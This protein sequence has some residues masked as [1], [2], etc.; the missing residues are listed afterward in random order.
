MPGSPRILVLR[1]SQ[2]VTEEHPSFWTAEADLVRIGT[3]AEALPLLLTESF[4]GIYISRR[5]TYFGTR[6]KYYCRT[7]LFLKSSAKA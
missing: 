7:R 3:L 2:A 6:P 1:G 4:A 5:M